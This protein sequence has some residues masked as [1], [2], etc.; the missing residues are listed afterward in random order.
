MVTGRSMRRDFFRSIRKSLG[1]YLAIL[2]I[3][4]LGAGFFAGLRSTKS[5]ML[6]TAQQYVDGQSLFDFR[7]LNTYGYTQRAVEALSAAP[8]VARAEGSISLDALLRRQDREE[9]QVYRL[10]SLT[11]QVDVVQLQVGRMPQTADE[12]LADGYFFGQDDLGA[13]LTL[14]QA[15]DPET[16]EKLAETSFTIVGLCSS[17]LYMSFERGSTTLGDG[18]IATFLY[19]PEEAFALDGVYTEV[20]LNLDGAYTL[21]SPAYDQALEQAADPLEDLAGTLARDRFETVRA[22]ARQALADGEAEYQKGLIQ[23]QSEKAQA[24]AQLEQAKTEL[25]DGWAELER[26]KKTL[27]EAEA[28]LA[29]AQAQADRG[30][31]ELSQGEIRLQQEK[32]KTYAQLADT[33][34]A[35]AQQYQQA[36]DGLKQLKDG[37]TQ[38]EDGLSRLD[39]GLEQLASGLEQL[40]SGLRLVN[41]GLSAARQLLQV[42]EQGL[43]ATPE[44]PGLLAAK[45]EL[46]QRIAELEQ[47]QSE[48]LAQQEQLLAQQAD[49]QAQKD[50]LAEQADALTQ[51][52]KE[53]ED[54][55]EQIQAGF[56]QVDAARGQADDQFASAQAQL[57]ASRLELEAG[58]A[59][60]DQGQ[61]ELESG[62]AQWDQGKSE[63]EGAQ[64][65]FDAA[66]AKADRELS[67]AREKLD[68]AKQDLADGRRD[69][70][71]LQAPDTYVLDRNT[72]V[73]YVSY[74][75][76][77]DIVAGVSRVFPLF[78]F[79]VAALV[80]ITTMTKM[81]DEERT[82]IGVM[83]A[84]GYDGAGIMAKYLAYAG[85]AALLGCLVGV[86][87]G[88]IV[89]PQMIWQAYTILYHFSSRIRLAFDWPL[90]GI[91][92]V[93]YTL[94]MLAVTW[95]CCRRELR[96][97]PADLIRP[98]SPKAGKRLLLERLPFWG[99]V[100]FLHK[101][102]IRNIFRYRKRLVMM[103]L[104]IGGCTALVLTGFGIKDSIAGVVDQQFQTV[105][106]YDIAVSFQ[107][108]QDPADQAA[109]WNGCGGAVQDVLFLHE[110]VVD[111]SAGGAVK[112][113]RLLAAGGPLEGFVDLHRGGE[114]VAFPGPGEAVINNGEAEALGLGVG[115]KI[116]VRTGDLK[117]LELTVSGIFDN[118]VYHY[119]IVSQETVKA[120]WGEA[121]AEATAYLTVAQEQDVHQAAAV[122]AAQENVLS[123]SVSQDMRTRV[124]S[125]MKSM[126]AIVVLVVFCAAALAFIVLYNL[127]NINITER[128]REIATIKVLGFFPRESASYVFREGLALTGMGCAL[129][130]IGGRFLHAFVMDQIR[131]DMVHFTAQVAWTSYLWSVGLTFLFA[132]IVDFF[133]FFKLEKINM[134]EALKSVE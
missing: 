69:L 28:A 131:I 54:G 90:C 22:E 108:N 29:Q 40:D 107:G 63:L 39:G 117:T 3:I 109:F 20:A 15:N 106:V 66:Q 133:L 134:A 76:D 99:R 95:F 35:L 110:S 105:T 116:T 112:S 52:K 19:L 61:L 2:A 5:A 75:S 96:S 64:A 130:L 45:A 34:A 62:K 102:A 74:E 59:E 104:G 113:S 89:F 53:L 1:R 17:P 31:R 57:E 132:C 60:I 8:G 44:D 125:T 14:S 123:V 58:Q 4:A 91:V 30:S 55:L 97:V 47:Q 46:E 128:V 27:D 32:A 129:G 21:Y 70:A 7:V 50:A 77:A 82:Q 56:V 122:V 83:K 88:S 37:L 124:D 41:T 100:G 86:I 127:T 103:L 68:Q 114:P 87:G 33:E 48:L 94:S 85:S 126:D 26:Q 73:G 42:V 98:K 25:D 43:L 72:N 23:Y 11:R 24:R 12:C 6:A 10:H 36:T 51:Q 93:S 65:E 38:V 118:N 115:D 84:L 101:V 119:V 92:V 120:Q 121:A 18:T 49:L 9:D 79:L 16:A 13:T 67:Q 71:E 78:F 80:C 111:V 81:V